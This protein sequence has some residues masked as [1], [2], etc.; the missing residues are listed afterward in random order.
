MCHHRGYPFL[1]R[2]KLP[3]REKVHQF[4]WPKRRSPERSKNVHKDIRKKCGSVLQLGNCRRGIFLTGRRANRGT[5]LSPENP[6]AARM[7]HPGKGT[8][9]PALVKSP[10]LHRAE[11]GTSGA[12]TQGLPI[13]VLWTRSCAPVE[14]M[15]PL[16]GVRWLAEGNHCNAHTLHTGGC[17]LRRCDPRQGN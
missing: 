8:Q 14:G 11:G 17:R 16:I 15:G 13:G 6:R 2:R 3:T 7:T 9:P 12:P 1:W 5:I 10:R 4:F